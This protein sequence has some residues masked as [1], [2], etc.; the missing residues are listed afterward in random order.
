MTPCIE[1]EGAINS[2][3]YGVVRL[4]G[5]LMLAH[6]VAYRLA[7][8]PIPKGK[9]VA[10]ECHNRKCRNPDHLHAQTH[11]ENCAARKGRAA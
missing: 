3:G 6:R 2:D 10:H 8:G 1:W 9:E 5:V 11:Q 4:N 7:K